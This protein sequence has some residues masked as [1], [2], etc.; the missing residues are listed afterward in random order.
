MIIKKQCAPWSRRCRLTAQPAEG[1]SPGKSSCYT[2]ADPQLAAHLDDEASGP[3]LSLTIA[4]TPYR[5]EI[6]HDH[7][8]DHAHEHDHDHEHAHE[9]DAAGH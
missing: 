2:S 6:H 8:H 9:H 3:K 7:E 1:D 5:G 4:G